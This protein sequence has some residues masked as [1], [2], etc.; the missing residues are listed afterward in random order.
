MPKY[1]ST[2]VA[3]GTAFDNSANGFSANNAQTA[4]EELAV[5]SAGLKIY[6]T[7]AQVGTLNISY[8]AGQ[9]I[10]NGTFRSF[11]AGTGALSPNLTNY[12]I[13]AKNDGT[14][15]VG[16]SAFVSADDA[17]ILCLFVTNATQVTALVDVRTS[18]NNNIIFGSSGDYT[19]IQPND[20]ANAGVLLRYATADHRHAIVT[21]TAVNLSTSSTS[22]EGSGTSFARADHTHK[23]VITNVQ[24]T[25]TASTTTAATTGAPA[26]MSGM[27]ITPAAGDYFAI[28]STWTDH[29]NQV[30]PIQISLAIA[31][32][33][34]THTIREIENRTNAVGAQSLSGGASTHSILTVNGSQA[35]EGRW[36][37]GGATATAYHRCLLLLKVN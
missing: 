12:V 35:I 5:S 10:F 37:T 22:T 15:A 19:T 26:V 9:A 7:A 31:G 16:A 14:I 29:S 28:F 25:A 24:V 18:L 8:T 27:T 20:A 34:Q 13:Y 23:I 17:V 6:Q 36:G 30:T 32:T 11:V 33:Q 21:A 3:R 4:I 2:P 1:S